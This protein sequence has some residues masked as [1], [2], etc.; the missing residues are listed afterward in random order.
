M[1]AR[2]VFTVAMSLPESIQMAP[3]MASTVSAS[4]RG[5]AGWPRCDGFTVMWGPTPARRAKS[6][7]LSLLATEATM[8]LP[9]SAP[10]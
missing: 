8:L 1:V 7:M 3:M 2:A 6:R 4:T 5:P 10:R 9:I